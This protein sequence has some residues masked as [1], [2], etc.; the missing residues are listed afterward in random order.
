M[1][2]YRRTPLGDRFRLSFYNGKKWCRVW[3]EG[4]WRPAGEGWTTVEADT[5]IF[6]GVR[7]VPPR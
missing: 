1:T 2:G 4:F 7:V 3:S 6:G 5:A